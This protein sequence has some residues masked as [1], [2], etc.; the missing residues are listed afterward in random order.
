MTIHYGKIISKIICIKFLYTASEL[1]VSISDIDAHTIVLKPYTNLLDVVMKLLP[2]ACIYS[3]KNKKQNKNKKNPNKKNQPLPIFSGPINIDHIWHFTGMSRHKDYIVPTWDHK[4][5]HC[6]NNSQG[7]VK[8]SIFLV[9]LVPCRHLSLWY[10][11]INPMFIN[12][13]HI[14]Q[15]K[16]STQG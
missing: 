2:I 5:V 1:C 11:F 6:L 10:A 8:N 9:Y 3:Y 14:N 16:Y 15:L 4:I 7:N 12:K 13:D